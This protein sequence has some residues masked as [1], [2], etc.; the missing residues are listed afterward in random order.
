MGD[1]RNAKSQRVAFAF[2]FLVVEDTQPHP[3][4]HVCK[5]TFLTCSGL[6]E[7]F[8]YPWGEGEKDVL[9]RQCLPFF[10]FLTSLIFATLNKRTNFFFTLLSPYLEFSSPTLCQSFEPAP[11]LSGLFTCL[12]NSQHL[13]GSFPILPH[14]INH[15]LL[16]GLCLWI[17]LYNIRTAHFVELLHH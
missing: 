17:S 16:S 3:P 6:C 14:S 1:P 8:L 7:W 13:W 9:G 5:L 10:L 4:F 11:H 12:L 15:S 2:S